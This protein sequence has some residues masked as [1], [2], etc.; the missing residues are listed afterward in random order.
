MRSGLKL[1]EIGRQVLL[2]RE[3]SVEDPGTC[4]R[5][6]GFVFCAMVI[7]SAKNIFRTTVTLASTYNFKWG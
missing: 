6:T 3:M 5:L 7:Q 2:S 1:L 4:F